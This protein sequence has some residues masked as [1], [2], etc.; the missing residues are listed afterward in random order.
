MPPKLLGDH[1]NHAFANTQYCYNVYQDLCTVTW[2]T[3][4]SNWFTQHPHEIGETYTQ[5]LIFALKMLCAGLAAIIHGI[6]PSLFTTTASAVLDTL[7]QDALHRGE[8][9]SN[10]ND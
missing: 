3:N 5:H 9:S 8:K 1:D 10:P 6:F 2:E 4:M 7:R